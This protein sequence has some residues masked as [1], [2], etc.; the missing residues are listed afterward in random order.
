MSILSLANIDF[1]ALKHFDFTTP[2]QPHGRFRVE[3]ETAP[4]QNKQ[5]AASVLGK[6]IDPATALAESLDEYDMAPELEKPA[7][8]DLIFQQII[9]YRASRKQSEDA[10]P[11]GKRI[12]RYT[13]SL[14]RLK[15]SPGRKRK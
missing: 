2:K 10:D 7:L 13:N 11:L 8:Q 1:E 15:K 14:A 6:G 4:K 5:A 3:G 12:A 9:K